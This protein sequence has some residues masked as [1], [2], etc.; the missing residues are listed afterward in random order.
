MTIYFEDLEIGAIEGFGRYEVTREQVIEFASKFD[1]QPFHLDDDA[2]AKSLFGKIAASGWHTAGMAMRMVV[3]HWKATGVAE[4]SLGGAG[5]DEVRWPHPVYPGDILRCEIE[6]LEKIPSRSKP[7]MG[8]LKSRWNVYNQND[9]LVMTMI[10][11]GL[12]RTRSAENG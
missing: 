11:T 8:I 10:S 4:T 3:D 6:L 9:V 12:I 7:F 2:A 1:P 5:M